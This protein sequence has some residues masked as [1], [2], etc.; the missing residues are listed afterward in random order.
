LEVLQYNYLHIDFVD[1]HLDLGFECPLDLHYSY[2]VDQ[3]MA[4][5]SPLR[6][7]CDK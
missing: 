6:G 4:A 7:L 1:K 2:S 5:F 3:I